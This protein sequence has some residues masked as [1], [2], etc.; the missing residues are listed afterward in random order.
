MYPIAMSAAY[1]KILG[2]KPGWEQVLDTERIDTIVWPRDGAVVQ[3]LDH[4][5]AWKRIR[6]DKV[7][8]TFIRTH[9][10]P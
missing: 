10:Q 2:L 9:P 8:A 5:P 4:L 7:A 6:T 1:N 3:V